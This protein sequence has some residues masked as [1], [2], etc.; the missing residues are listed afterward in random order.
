MKP[1]LILA[2]DLTGAADSAARCRHAGFAATIFLQPPQ[3][4]FLGDVLA[5]TSDSRYLSAEDAAHR[6]RAVTAPLSLLDVRWYKKVDS[7]LR[8]HLGSELD[9]LLDLGMASC[10]VICPAFPA[11]GRALI[12]G[13]L[14]AP[15][16]TAQIHLPTLLKTQ[17]RHAVAHL[18][19]EDVRSDGAVQ[20][21]REL[22]AD[23]AKLIV[24]DA[25]EDADLEAVLA[26]VEAAA[27][28]VLL[29]GSAGLIGAWAA[30]E[31]RSAASSAPVPQV[32]M[33][34]GAKL[35]CLLVIGSGSDMAQR[36]IE[37]LRATRSLVAWTVEP[38]A[39]YDGVGETMLLHLPRPSHGTVLDGPQARVSAEQL[40]E[41]AA[42]VIARTSPSLL[43]LSGG[44]TAMHVLA[45]LGIERLTVLAEWLPGMPLCTAVDKHRRAYK[46]VLK[47][48]SFG[49][50]ETL[51]TLLDLIRN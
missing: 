25:A 9:A 22:I 28:D 7:T 2:D 24:V 4:P 29:C 38:G 17:S 50:E 35:G 30:R 18:L 45:R 43:I 1:L 21:V 49:Q 26:A 42:E 36:Q 46:I 20:K 48:G 34:V 23:G 11:Q 40:A 5:F 32:E 12:D 10:A 14:V 3:P 47:P 41:A 31:A 6:V 51:I 44:D 16:V 39:T 27:A 15:G 37:Q 13:M 19:L 8:G 33:P